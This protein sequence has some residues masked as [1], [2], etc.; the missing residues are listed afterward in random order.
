METIEF[1]KEGNNK[2][3]LVVNDIV[4]GWL[5]VCDE[6]YNS[7]RMNKVSID[8]SFRGCGFYKM[9]IE[10]AFKFFNIECLRSYERNTKSNPIYCHWT[11]EDLYEE[12]EVYITM[13]NGNLVF[14]V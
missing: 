8:E 3:E 6:G 14:T 7:Y 9:L 2:V 4:C 11:G 13:E 10:K 5:T 12:Q 1:C